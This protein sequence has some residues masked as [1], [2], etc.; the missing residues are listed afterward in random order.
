MSSEPT[1]LIL[2]K[3]TDETLTAS[4]LAFVWDKPADGWKKGMGILSLGLLSFAGTTDRPRVT[5]GI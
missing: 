4:L 3:Q 1:P 2:G 5:G